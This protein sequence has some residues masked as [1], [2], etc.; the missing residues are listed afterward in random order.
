M[1][2]IVGNYKR[3][4]TDGGDRTNKCFYKTVDLLSVV[5]GA[6]YFN[7]VAP[8][9]LEVGDLIECSL[10]TDGNAHMATLR[11]ASVT[12]GVVVVVGLSQ[13]I[14]TSGAVLPGVNS[15]ELYSPTVSGAIAATV[16]SSIA[17][18]DGIFCAKDTTSGGTASLTLT[19]TAGTFDGT[20]AVATFDAPHE[21]IAIKFDSVGDGTIIENVGSV[22]F[23]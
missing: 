4:R 21:A 5:M 17:H 3:L 10:D 9:T 11:V 22:S 6:G 1:A 19:L 15:V 16:A 2:F 20:N 12:S 23:S 7:N 18:Q 14:T 13:Q 8:D